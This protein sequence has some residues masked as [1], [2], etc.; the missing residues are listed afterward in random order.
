MGA[1]EAP[2][3]CIKV[4]VTLELDYEIKGYSSDTSLSDLF[5]HIRI[6]L[7]WLSMLCEVMLK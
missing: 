1:L 6:M 4:D 3:T 2:S 7:T 5:L